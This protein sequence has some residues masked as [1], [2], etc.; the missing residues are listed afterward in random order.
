[1]LAQANK[2]EGAMKLTNSQEEYLKT[3]YLLEKNKQKVRVTDIAK[4]MNITK[5][6]VNKGLKVL[7]EIKLINYE[8]YGNINLTKQGQE[9]AKEIIKKQDILE[10]FLIG[11]LEIEKNQ[12]QEEA[13]AIKCAMSKESIDKL[14]LYISKI[15]DL[16]D[17]KCGYDKNNEK[18]RSCIKITARERLKKA[19]L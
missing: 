5:P 13:K 15:L 10:T 3:I 9:Q 11:I 8:V 1:M 4:K 18:C 16:E 7:K 17:L 2:K 19:R 12:A 14:D 6:S